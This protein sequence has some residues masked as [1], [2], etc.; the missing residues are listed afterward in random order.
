M[1]VADS[2]ASTPAAG[3]V[4]APASAEGAVRSYTGR[5]R[6][7]V[8]PTVLALG[9]VSLITDVSSEMV[10][11]VLPLYLVAGL[12]LSPLGFGLLDGVYNGFSALVR[13]AGGHLADRGRGGHKWVAGLGYG[14]SALCKPLL[15]LAHG[16]TPIGLVLAADRTGKGLRT[17]PR[18]ALIS[19]SSTPENQGRAFGVHRAMDTAGA[20]LGPLA[21]FWILRATVDGY[22]AVFTVSFCVAA[23][24]VLVLVLFVPNTRTSPRPDARPAPSPPPG[25]P[26]AAPHPTL[27]A[28]VALLRHQSL[29]RITICALLLGLA[30]VSDS[31]VYLLLQRRLGVPDRWFALLPLGTAAA[32]LLLAVPLGRLA[33]RVG[34]WHV[35]LAGHGALLL[36]YALLLTSWH[37]TALPYAVLLLHGSFYA[38]TDGVLMAAASAG[39]PPE[40]R[41][42][43][44][45]L[46]QTGQATARFVCSLGFGAAWTLWG[47]RTALTVSAVAL[48][49]CAVFSFTLRPRAKGTAPA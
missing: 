28:A 43:G 45:A 21:A 10:T 23:V 47:D 19:L 17:A 38:A 39:V 15:L 14:I 37:G 27:R 4:E 33:D 26:E 7:A 46:V 12:G 22:D 29:R 32:F 6:A 5:R 49:A 13:L 16:L 18:D 11:A 8:A 44:L 30:T 34:R 2:R 35:F 3:A 25:N 1:Y 24:G 48:A 20:L 31:F 42:S 40:L 9:T 36:A 41:S